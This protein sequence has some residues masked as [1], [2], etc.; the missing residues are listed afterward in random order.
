MTRDYYEYPSFKAICEE[1]C[2]GFV[3]EEGFAIVPCPDCKE[4]TGFTI[5]N[6]Q[7]I[8]DGQYTFSDFYTKV[9]YYHYGIDLKNMKLV[10]MDMVEHEAFMA[11]EKA[12]KEEYLAKEKAKKAKEWME[13]KAKFWGTFDC[14]KRLPNIA[15]S[16]TQDILLEVGDTAYVDVF[17]SLTKYVCIKSTKGAADWEV[18]DK[19]KAKKPHILLSGTAKTVKINELD[20]KPPISKP[21]PKFWGTFNSISKLPN[22]AGS[23]TQIDVLM[24]GDTAW[25][26]LSDDEEKLFV[27]TNPT[28]GAAKWKPNP[29]KKDKTMAKKSDPLFKNYWG[30]FSTYSDLPNISGSSIQDDAL[31]AGDLAYLTSGHTLVQCV[32]STMDAAVWKEKAT[33][34]TLSEYKATEP[35]P[36]FKPEPTPEKIDFREIAL[37]ALFK[38]G[39]SE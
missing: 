33:P 12:K 19:E 35:E 32:D 5:K 38:N 21:K 28:K 39:D 6:K 3:E 2:L 9:K 34:E 8:F 18:V 26:D 16:P 31:G 11:R 17:P 1:C 30:N 36:E 14:S 22:V 20:Y 27:C 4:K 7:E 15:G 10:D 24:E 37:G 25:V 13:K 29:A 23:S